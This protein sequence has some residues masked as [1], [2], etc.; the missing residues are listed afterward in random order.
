MGIE[1][2][3]EPIPQRIELFPV[4]PNP[5][6]GSLVLRFGLP[7]PSSVIITIL[8]MSGRLIS[9]N[10]IEEYSTGFHNVILGNLPSG[11]YFCR[12]TSGNFS[13][14]QRFVVIE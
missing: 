13:A 4:A 10:F 11:L 3:A 8:D 2:T 1:E 14:S 6:T 5:V 9:K 12:M 7:E